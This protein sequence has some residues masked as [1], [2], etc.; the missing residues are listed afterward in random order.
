MRDFL[1][2]MGFVVASFLLSA[3]F[4]GLPVYYFGMKAESDFRN[5]CSSVQGVAVNDDGELECH[6]NGEEI[7]ELGENSPKQPQKDED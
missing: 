2:A 7:A 3:L 4:I 1:K 5:E 6:V